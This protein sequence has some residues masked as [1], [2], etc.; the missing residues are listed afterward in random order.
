MLK[1]HTVNARLLERFIFNF[2][3]KPK[4]LTDHLPVEHLRPQVFHGWSVVSF[5]IL[6]LDR[7]MLAQFPSKLGLKTISC[8]YR[9][10]VIDT[11]GTQPVPAVYIL[12][13]YTDNSLISSL[14]PWILADSIAKVGCSLTRDG[15]GYTIHVHHNHQCLF[16]A[17][18]QPSSTP[19]VLDS[20]I[21]E[22]IDDFA[23]F[24]KLGVTSYTPA[25]VPNA[26]TRVDLHKN[27]SHYTALNATVKYNLLDDLW[28]NT[29][30]TFDSAVQAT[31]GVY[32]WTY[33]GAVERNALPC[34]M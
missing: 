10:G 1:L 34:S 6:K 33:R 15:D 14:G 18:I 7:V 2:R 20:H 32:I 8:A 17:S 16:S 24:L 28:S 27:D 22:S 25:I 5:C 23:R 19:C 26:L 11:F 4:L 31:G 3:V 9:C 12:Q 29:E 21:F 13:R 30:L